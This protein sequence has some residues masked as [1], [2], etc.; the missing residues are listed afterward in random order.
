[1][2]ACAAMGCSVPPIP[3]SRV[4]DDAVVTP[5]WS[6]SV[7][8]PSSKRACPDCSR[9]LASRYDLYAA[10]IGP[11]PRWAKGVITQLQRD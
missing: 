7:G 9:A 4:H 6:T 1:M 5:A 8:C 10:L 3:P 11:V 2:T